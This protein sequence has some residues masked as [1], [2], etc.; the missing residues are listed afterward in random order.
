MISRDC[1]E[2]GRKHD[3]R[4]AQVALLGGEACGDEHG[5]TFE[6]STREKDQIGGAGKKLIFIG[7]QLYPVSPHVEGEA[8]FR[9]LA[10]A[11]VEKNSNSTHL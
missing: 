7:D 8:G 4:Q 1:P 10:P 6:N 5:F 2:P 11:G 3:H 9:N